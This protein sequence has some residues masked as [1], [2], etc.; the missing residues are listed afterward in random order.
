MNRLFSRLFVS[1]FYKRHTGFLLF[2]FIVC[3]AVVQAS[4]LRAYHLAIM[5]TILGSYWG[6]VMLLIAWSS[7]LL[8]ATQPTHRLIHSEEGYFLHTLRA[9]SLYSQA[10]L[11][12]LVVLQWYAPVLIYG[13][14]LAYVALKD[15]RP[16]MSATIII[17]LCLSFLL[18]VRTLCRSANRASVPARFHLP[19]LS[20]HRRLLPFCCWPLAH[21]WHESRRTYVIIKLFSIVL[22]YIPFV[23]NGDRYDHDSP[24]LFL[25]A[26]IAANSWGAFQS[27]RFVE[28]PLRFYRNLPLPSFSVWATYIFTYTVFLL[29]EAGYLAWAGHSLLTPF[30]L[31]CIW[32]APLATLLFLTA[33]QY[34]NGPGREE[35]L[36]VLGGLSFVSL[37]FF[38]GGY[39]GR[40]ALILLAIGSFLFF[41]NQST[42]EDEQPGA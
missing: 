25:V 41:Y 6:F 26:L 20:E 11:F 18:A 5:H 4:S 24:V 3:F 8:R 42:Y 13:S 30:E 28:G 36:K 12:A 34:G 21:L 27:V 40:W 2:A 15:G 14:L 31:F 37:F 9:R 22:L 1:P 16:A 17:F 35:F 19:R 23:W 39:F 10:R 32:L 33:V 29:P 38:N 7:W